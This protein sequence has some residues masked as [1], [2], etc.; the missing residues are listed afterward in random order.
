MFKRY[1]KFV[2]RIPERHYWPLFIILSLYFVVPYSEFVVTLGA[3]GYF[4][5]EKSYR[6]FFAKV[7]SPLPDVI[8]YGGSV[9]FFLVML[10]DTIFYAAIILAALWSNRE[11]KK[12]N[13][14]EE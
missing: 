5:F 11:A 2:A 14:S 12:I 10:D 9:I 7:I 1:L 3:L 8:K 13:K 4:K 6:K